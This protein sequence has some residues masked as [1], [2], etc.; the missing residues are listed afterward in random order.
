[1]A[2]RSAPLL[3]VALGRSKSLLLVLIAAHGGAA[4]AVLSTVPAWPWGAAALLVLT[5]SAVHAVRRHALRAGRGAVQSLQ[6]GGGGECRLERADGSVA[7]CRVQGSSY[8]SPRLVVLHLR[9]DG[10]RLGH[11]VVLPADSVP[12]DG[13]RR[14]RALLRWLDTG[15]EAQASHD[16]RL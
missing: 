6:L 5:A 2:A 7:A 8:V 1:M 3:R 11:Y 10:R 12:A 16:P 15:A 14:L 9:E 4:A 13:F